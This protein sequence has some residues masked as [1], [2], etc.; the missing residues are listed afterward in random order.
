MPEQLSLRQ[1]HELP[2]RLELELCLGGWRSED[3][4][5][6]GRRNFVSA[7]GRESRE[8]RRLKRG[9]RLRRRRRQ[10][11]AD[12][13]DRR[14]T[15]CETRHPNPRWHREMLAAALA[16]SQETEVARTHLGI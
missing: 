12:H 14:T 7:G 2:V 8:G 15:D 9:A 6:R 3:L 13:R 1:R 11:K 16:L 4:D 10:G 5:R